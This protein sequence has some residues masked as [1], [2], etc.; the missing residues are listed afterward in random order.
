[1]KK[2]IASLVLAVILV[3]SIT[4]CGTGG[5]SQSAKATA[6]ADENGNYVVNGSFEAEDFTGWTINNI[7]NVTEE[8]DV[9]TRDTDAYEGAQSL[10]FYSGSSNV[11]FTAEQEISGLEAGN[12]K[13]TAHVQ[14]DAAGDENAVV[15]F[16][17]IVDGNKVTAEGT[18]GGY[19][20]W[21]TV[22]LSGLNTTEGNITVGVS[23]ST[24]PGGW[25]TIDDITLVK[26]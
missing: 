4:G 2:R 5:S 20:N 9:Y 14:G 12:Y 3:G 21:D 23:V 13:M 16:Y 10:H 26:E 7:D 8:L 22:E 15:E 1:M 18:L 11:N 24:A 17:A 19:V 6:T 25:G